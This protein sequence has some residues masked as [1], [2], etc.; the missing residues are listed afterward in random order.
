MDIRRNPGQEEFD[1]FEWLSHYN[2][3]TIH[4]LTKTDKL[5]KSKQAVRHQAIAT[6]L[7]KNKGDLI[8]FSAKSRQGKDNLWTAIETL[9]AP[10]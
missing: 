6:S 8:L 7:S 9:I 10:F 4:V 1:L 3:P 5:S 2:I